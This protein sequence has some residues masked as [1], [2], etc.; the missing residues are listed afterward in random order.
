MESYNWKHFYDAVFIHFSINFI[1]I[2]KAIKFLIET[3]NRLKKKTWHNVSKGTG[4]S[5]IFLLDNVRS[6]IF[7]EYEEYG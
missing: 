5:Y 3:K 7:E 2:V 1:T 4:D 6:D